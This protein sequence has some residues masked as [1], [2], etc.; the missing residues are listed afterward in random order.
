MAKSLA[1]MNKP[2]LISLVKDLKAQI[3]EPQ[4][5]LLAECV[6]SEEEVQMLK[7][8]IEELENVTPHYVSVNDELNDPEYIARAKV[9]T[10]ARMG[11]RNP[12]G[13]MGQAPGAF[14]EA[15]RRMYGKETHR[16]ALEDFLMLA[17]YVLAHRFPQQKAKREGN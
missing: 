13:F 12:D 2:E 9:A 3:A 6:H 10:R 1:Q 4:K 14:M 17:K 5:D 15:V 8:R 16:E 7:A 11:V